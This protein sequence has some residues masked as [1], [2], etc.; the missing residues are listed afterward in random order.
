MWRAGSAIAALLVLGFAAAGFVSAQKKITD[1]IF[2]GGRLRFTCRIEI[3]RASNRVA[4]HAGQSCN[5]T[6]PIQCSWFARP[7]CRNDPRGGGDERR[8]YPL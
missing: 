1:F 4:R 2:R 6:P 5:R 3:S 8:A 7:F